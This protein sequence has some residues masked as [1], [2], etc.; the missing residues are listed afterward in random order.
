MI[1]RL[2]RWA[3]RLSLLGFYRRVEI[4]G[5]ELIPETGPMLVVANHTNAFVDPLI[6]LTGQRRRVTLTAKSTLARNPLLAP[7]IKGLG[8]VLLHRSDDRHR[9]AAPEQNV[10]ALAACVTILTN[11]G[12]VFVFP[13]GVSHSDPAMRP[14]KTGAARLVSAFLEASPDRELWIV[15]VGLHFTKK[16]RWRS[17]ALALV[18]VPVQAR[19]WAGRQPASADD[20]RVDVRTL[21]EAMRGWVEALTMNFSSEE[22]RSLLSGAERLLAY[23]AE[24]PGPLDRPAEWDSRTR[25]DRVHR[26]QR[27]AHELRRRD[28]ERFDLLASRARSLNRQLD[29]LGVGAEEVSLS[30]HAGRAAL[31]VVRELEVLLVGAPVAFL[32][33]GVHLP[34]L[35]LTRHLVARM[36]VDE[37][38]T[39]S[40]AVFLSIPIFGA[41]WV[42][43]GV[44]GGLLLPAAW[45][46]VALLTV[47]F[48]AMV[49]LHY[50]DRA[51]GVLR[52]IRTFVLWFRRPDLRERL[53]ADI[54]GWHEQVRAAEADFPDPPSRHTPETR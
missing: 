32:G 17:E 43:L 19:E 11:G 48:T 28:P 22:E 54:T 12:A 40:N 4:Q 46:T 25:V 13:E 7:V 33:W 49:H 50:R 35:S 30:M 9:G 29:T 24:G 47:W 42:A 36:S 21:T 51:G 53:E 10:E 45:A 16:D 34:P 37:D 1:Y 31:F 2:V 8:V 5:V 3:L 39:A 20:G 44:L 6:V 15:P 27:G 23:R 14:F 38:H 41:W 52:R 26:L 18:G